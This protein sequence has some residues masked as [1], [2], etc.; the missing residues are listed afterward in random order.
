MKTLTPSLYNAFYYYRNGHSSEEDFLEILLRE[1]LEQTSLML[2]GIEF[3]EKVQQATAKEHCEDNIV[4]EVADIVRGGDWQVRCGKRLG[5]Y[6]LYGRCDVA[7]DDDIF[8][9]K[10]VK[11]Y[12]LNK[13]YNSIQH[14]V[15]MYAL[16][17]KRF[18]YLIAQND[19]F[20]VESYFWDQ[21][22]LD[23]LQCRVND[24]NNFIYGVQKYKDIYEQK[25]MTKCT[26]IATVS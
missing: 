2:E 24:F 23:L 1:P 10:K 19:S 26:T 11:H 16:D 22:A 6:W 7:K 8:D 21:E 17:I 15:Y 3:E 13:Y 14:L 25:W 18:H 5:D 12:D 4:S 9:I 20:F